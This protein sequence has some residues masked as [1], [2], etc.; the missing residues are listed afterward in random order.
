MQGDKLHYSKAVKH[1]Q[2]LMQDLATLIHSFI[3]ML[4]RP[5]KHL[6]FFQPVTVC[7]SLRALS[8]HNRCGHLAYDS[9]AKIMQDM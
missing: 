1:G 6:V 8:T 2:N 3:V 4:V 5:A 7:L 9:K